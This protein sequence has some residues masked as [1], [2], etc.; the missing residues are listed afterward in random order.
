MNPPLPPFLTVESDRKG[1]RIQLLRKGKDTIHIGPNTVFSFILHQDCDHGVG[2]TPEW[3]ILGQSHNLI[4]NAGKDY[5]SKALGGKLGFGVSGTIA[6]ATSATSLT[7]TATPFVASAYIGQIVIAE[8]STNAPVWGNIG[9]NSTSVLTVD[10]W[11]NGDDSSGTTPSSTANYQ[12]LP[13]GGMARYMA[14]TESGTAASASDT[15]LPSE[16][17][18]DGLSR[19]LATF[20]HSDGT[21]TYTLTK[22][23]SVTGSHP[24]IHKMGLL[25]ASTSTAAGVL[26]YETV[27]NADANVV[28]GD[29][30]TNVETVTLT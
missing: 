13:G 22:A 28:N 15:T 2:H 14:L 7:A 25:T 24:A 11:F 6:T 10:A 27:L 5:V 12:I 18:I 29:T 26:C 4:T 1:A 9:A 21:N 20:A 17:T 30:L 8:Q 16:I 23:Y 19:A 3:E